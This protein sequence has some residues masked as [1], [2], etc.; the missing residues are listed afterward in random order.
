MR[1]YKL[2]GTIFNSI[3]YLFLLLP[4]IV[5]IITSFGEGNR[6]V[7]PA[8]G[9]TL[10]WY[11]EAL[12]NVDF[13]ESV[14]ISLKIAVV[15]TLISA[16][17]GTMVS[18]YFWKTKGRLKEIFELIFM[19]PMVVPT[20]AFSSWKFVVPYWKLV[21][22]YCAIQIPYVIRSVTAALYGLDVSFEEASLVLGARPMKTL[23][24]VTLPCIK[25][26]IISGII[27]AFVVSFDEAVII[28]FLRNA[29]TVTYPLRLYTHITEQFSPM[30]S[31]F[32]AV[33]IL[34]SFLVI[35]VIERIFGLSNMYQ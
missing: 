11:T 12:H 27:F 25:R 18:L 13:F 24:K 8:H 10:K 35:Y 29:S 31:A 20:V 4:L 1:K 17:L 15:S 23:Y 16:V 34:I 14:F 3:V 33:F 9:F 28:M 32:S 26:G 22:S 7:F 19:A 6:A 30:V 5:V 21:L 2:A